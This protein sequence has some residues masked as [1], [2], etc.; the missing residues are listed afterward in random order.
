MDGGIPGAEE[1]LMLLLTQVG[2]KEAALLVG[3]EAWRAALPAIDPG[4]R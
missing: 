1:L 3:E 4:G 2:L